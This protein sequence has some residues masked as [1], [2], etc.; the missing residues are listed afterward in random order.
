MCRYQRKGKK[1]DAM[2]RRK[3][4]GRLRYN[5][6]EIKLAITVLEQMEKTLDVMFYLMDKEGA[7]PFVTILI[8][9]EYE[10]LRMLLDSEKRNTDLL[11][12]VDKEQNLYTIICQE[13]KIDGAYRFAERFIR[14]LKIFKA[15]EIYAVEVEVRT[16]NH[17]AKEVVFKLIDTY[18]R[19]VHEERNGEI[20]FH[21]LR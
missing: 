12:E 14:A 18:V 5:E 19:A 16:N 2:E 3:K 17:T 6:D 9:A 7:R 1:M 11:F 10:D 15:K 8:S 20:G 13:T 21:S 4:R